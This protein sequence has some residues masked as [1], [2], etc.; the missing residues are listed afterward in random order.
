[1]WPFRYFERHE[2]CRPER[3][4]SCP[5]EAWVCLGAL[6]A[7][8]VEPLREA[9][10]HPLEVTSGFRPPGENAAAG[11]SM[12]S[13][14]LS[15]QAADLRSARAT[16]EALARLV[17]SLCLPFD[18]MII[19]RRASGEAWLHVSYGARHRREVL[20]CLDGHTYT[21]WRPDA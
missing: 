6:F 14:H 9:H 13:Q 10:G 16:P 3:A 15:G 21:P 7:A 20:V 17:L 2:M 12:S 4:T 18:Q 5:P 8:V 1:M 19:E 11:G